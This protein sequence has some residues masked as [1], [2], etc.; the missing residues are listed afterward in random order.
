MKKWKLL[1]ALVCVVLAAL[2]CFGC[3]QGGTSRTY[4]S[5][6]LNADPDSTEEE[7][8]SKEM[9]A[10][11]FVYFTGEDAA[12]QEQVYFSVS[13]NGVNW[14]ALNDREPVLESTLGEQGIRDPHIIRSPDGKKFYLIATDLSIYRINGNWGASQNS[15]SQSIVIWESEDL[16]NWSEPRL[17]KIARDNAG[18]TWAPESFYDKEREAYMIFWASKTKEDNYGTHRVYR[19]YTT[20][21]DTFTEPEVYIETEVSAIDTTFIEHD[22]V[23]YRFTKDEHNK[24]VYMEK[25]TSLSGVFTT[26]GTYTLDGKQPQWWYGYEGPTAF[27]M[28]GE[29]KWCLLLDNYGAGGYFPFVTDDL[30]S[31]RFTQAKGFTFDGMKCRHGSVLPI[32]LA[33]YNALLEKYPPEGKDNTPETGELIASFDFEENLDGTGTLVSTG[34]AKYGDGVNGGKALLLKGNYLQLTGDKDD[35]KPLAGLETMTVSFAAKRAGDGDHWLFYAAANDETQ[36]WKSEKYIGALMK[37]EEVQCERYNSSNQDRPRA[38]AGKIDDDWKYITI[39]YRKDRTNVYIDGVR[40]STEKSTV[41]IKTMLGNDPKVYFGMANWEAGQYADAWIDALRIYN[42][43]Q[44]ADEVLA[45]YKSVM[46]V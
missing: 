24:F 3:A 28:N 37:G 2:M 43:A 14:T 29:D 34:E 25:G 41:N 40:A 32:T 18:C 8:A 12:G 6:R 46:G 36:S 45:N 30:S 38:A 7:V 10:Y 26:V 4:R 35:A 9:E 22:G 13:Q 16:V 27:K 21:F 23:Y 44:S 20:D 15:G 39:V 42:Y 31:G 11:L 19:C 1:S 17:R 5:A 33:E